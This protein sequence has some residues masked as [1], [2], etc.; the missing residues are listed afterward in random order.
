MKNSFEIL[1]T[2]V[3]RKMFL[4]RKIS[5]WFTVVWSGIVMPS[6]EVWIETVFFR[7]GTVAGEENLRWKSGISAIGGGMY[8]YRQQGEGGFVYKSA[9]NIAAAIAALVDQ[10]Y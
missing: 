5:I 10:I 1:V 6:L 8:F 4:G 9:L 3:E 2:V 7:T